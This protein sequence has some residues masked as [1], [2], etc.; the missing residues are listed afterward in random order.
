[1]DVVLGVAGAQ[2]GFAGSRVR[3]GNGP[4]YTAEGQFAAGSVDAVVAP[5]DVERVVA[6]CLRVLAGRRDGPA[7]VPRALGRLDLPGTG[8]EAVRRARSAARPRA[9]AYLADHFDL[10]VPVR[11]DRAGGVD[12][13]VVCGLGLRGDRAVAVAAQLGTATGAAGYRTV[14]R[15]LRMAGRLGVPVLTLVDTPGAANGPEAERAGVGPAIAGVFAAVAESPVPVTTLVVGEGGSGGALALCAPGRT[16][17]TPDSYFSVLAPE[18]AG[19]VLR[20]GDVAGVAEDLR[21]RPQ[22]VVE[23]GAADGIAGAE[24]IG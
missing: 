1:A 18:L 22:D 10:L 23:L 3:P 16:W 17:L 21:L 4:E 13:G 20:R 11:G 8:W 6:D 7:E 19:L 2:V 24:P 9:G 15:L 12:D 14:E 5:G